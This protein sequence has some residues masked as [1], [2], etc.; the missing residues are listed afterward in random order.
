[1]IQHRGLREQQYAPNSFEALRE[2]Y[3]AA[4]ELDVFMLRDGTL[5]VLHNA[6]VKGAHLTQKQVEAMTLDELESLHVVDRST[7]QEGGAIPLAREYLFNAYDRGID[8]TIEVKASSPARAK[9]TVRALIDEIAAMDMEGVFGK[10]RDYLTNKVGIHSFS[11]EA[12]Q[13]AGD[14]LSVHGLDIR[15]GL[16][17]AS[18]PERAEEMEISRTAREF[19]GYTSD[20]YGQ[21]AELGIEAASRLG[22]RSINLFRTTITPEIVQRAHDAG[23]EV[24]AWVVND[25]LEAGRLLEMGVDKLITE[26]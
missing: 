7:S 11:V 6:D 13:A 14:A 10:S 22:C 15:R 8:M 18:A 4:H 2:Q 16:F 17:W 3:G 23:L 5:A 24:Y 19:V 1:M 9:L 20:Q 26:R 21:W 25:D 12:L